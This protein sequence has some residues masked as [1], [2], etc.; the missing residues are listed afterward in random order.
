MINA[1]ALYRPILRQAWEITMKYKHL[2]FFGLFAALVSSGGEY[3]I[4]SRLLNIQVGEGIIGG[5]MMGLQNAVVEGS[6]LGGMN[7]LVGLWQVLTQEPLTFITMIFILSV[8]ITVI[9]F[10]VWLS[11]ISQIGLIRNIDQVGKTTAA[12]SAK[13]P[14]INDGVDFGIKYFWPVL[15]INFTLRVV[16]S[17]LFLILGGIYLFLLNLGGIG[18]LIYTMLFV[19]FAALTLT[20]SFILR[21]QIFY[22]LLK[23]ESFFDSLKSAWQ[24]FTKNWIISLEMAVLM[25][26]I[27]IAAAIISS[28]AAV[29]L[30]AIPIAVLPIYFSFMPVVLK[31]LIALAAIIVIILETIAITSITAAFQWTNWT[32]LFNKISAKD[33]V[34]KL[35]RLSQSLQGLPKYFTK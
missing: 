33:E 1:K 8:T 32:I 6:K 9:I 21:Y 23:K 35:E 30:W 22:L 34:S 20:I 29:I 4:I 11:T 19:V 3:E 28:A 13:I 27:F 31:L 18:M 16:L 2:W 12:K 10:L 14:T 5:L 15:G 24:L 25:L 26:L 7:L 17:I